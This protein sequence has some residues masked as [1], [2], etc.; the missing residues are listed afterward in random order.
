M[1]SYLKKVLNRQP[2]NYGKLI[3]EGAL[4]IDV[5]TPQ[6]F[7]Q[8]HADNSINIPLSEITSRIDD[9][10][11]Q[12][13]PVIIC[14]RSGVR[15]GSATTLLKSAGVEAYNAGTWNQVQAELKFKN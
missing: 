10:K 14:C 15:A 7:A 9:V 11:E 4:I 5:R 3:E 8:G 6:E 12:N 1:L 2:L 13:K